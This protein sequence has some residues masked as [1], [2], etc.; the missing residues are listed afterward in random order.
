MNI[1]G[2]NDV[3]RPKMIIFDYGHTLVHETDMDF[4][5]GIKALMAF[6][7]KKN[8]NLSVEAVCKKAEELF[9]ILK[10]TLLKNNIEIKHEDF[11]R[12]LFDSLNISFPLTNDEMTTIF[13][14]AL[15]PAV[16][17]PG[18]K[19]IIE[20][21]MK[22]NIR[23]A[24]ISNLSFSENALRNRLRNILPEASFE[25]ILVSSSYIFR[26]PHPTMFKAALNIAGLKKEDVWYIGD[27]P[28]A[29]VE[30]A[31]NS[32]I[33]PVWFCPD[34]ACP[35]NNNTAQNMEGAFSEP[36]SGYIKIKKWEELIQIL[37]NAKK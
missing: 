28:A 9:G 27:N 18:V 19:R 2:C 25:F 8:G 32:G 13:W 30:G 34:L 3:K 7:T 12:A 35:Y 33:Q 15:A 20:F 21:C 26:K 23:T 17:M 5:K 37:K 4:K 36:K 11:H 22:K 6:A 16:P 1:D 31:A 24:V 10:N 29:D 14:E